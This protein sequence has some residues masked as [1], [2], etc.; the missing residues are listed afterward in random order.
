MAA[1]VI[2]NVEVKDPERY[3]EYKRM[4]GRAV[5]EHGGRFIV[6]GGAAEKLEGDI[7]PRR[8]VVVEFD[9]IE[10]ARAWYASPEYQ[11]ALRLRHEIAATDMILVEGV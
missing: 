10:A 5:A 2:V 7:A 9:D 4:A 6:R 11:P 1:Y 3:E 8:M